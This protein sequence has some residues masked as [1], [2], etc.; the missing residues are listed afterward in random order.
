MRTTI[1]MAQVYQQSADAFRHA[2]NFAPTHCDVRCTINDLLDWHARDGY[3]VA[4]G[5]S[6]DRAFAVVRRLLSEKGGA[7]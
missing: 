7:A 2:R 1:P 4:F 3:R 6:Q 5:Y